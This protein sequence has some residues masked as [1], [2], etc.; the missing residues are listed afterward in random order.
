M[1]PSDFNVKEEVHFLKT[2]FDRCFQEDD[3]WTLRKKC[4]GT[5]VYSAESPHFA[6]WMLKGETM[7]EFSP[8]KVYDLV[9]PTAEYRLQWDEHVESCEFLQ[10]LAPGVILVHQRMKPLLMG[11]ISARDTVDIIVQEEHDQHYQIMLSS[12]PCRKVPP[13]PKYVRAI[14]YPSGMA[15]YRTRN[16]DEAKIACI[17]QANLHLRRTPRYIIDNAMVTMMFN[18]LTSLQ[19]CK[20]LPWTPLQ[21]PAGRVAKN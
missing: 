20:D 14:S 3:S 17:I 21:N 18:Y 1:D 19:K 8:E 6:G 2:G 7:V 5:V 10:D 13:Q 15:I 11:L 16:P 12:V 9:H 4:H